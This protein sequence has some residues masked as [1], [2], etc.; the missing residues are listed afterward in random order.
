MARGIFDSPLVGVVN[1]G[2]V[3]L[4]NLPLVGRLVGRG[5]VV[6]RYVGRRSG[7]TFETPVGYRRRGD[8]IVIGIVAPDKKN[9]WRNFLDDGAP[10]T[11]LD[12]EGRD[13][14]GHAVAHRDDRGEVSVAVTLDG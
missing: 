9:W 3:R 11:L 14:T 13:R 6:I 1:A 4:L 8:T 5:L 2:V 10:I 7:T 12:F